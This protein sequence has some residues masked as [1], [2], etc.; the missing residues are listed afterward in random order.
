MS[1]P[2]TNDT[3]AR[4]FLA[5][6][7]DELAAV[8]PSPGPRRGTDR[9]AVLLFYRDGLV[10][11]LE[12]QRSGLVELASFLLEEPQRGETA[13]PVLRGREPPAAVLARLRRRRGLIL[14]F[15]PA[16]ALLVRDLLPAGAEAELREI[17]AH[18]LDVLTPWSADQAVFDVEVSR[19]REDGR[20]EV[21]V[22]VAPRAR[23][24]QLRSR[25]D[26]LGI[27]IERVDVGELDDQP[28]PRFDLLAG[29]RGPRRPTVLLAL[30]GVLA[31]AALA[32]LVVAGSEIH[33]RSV[34]LAERERV[35]NALAER[36]AD[37]PALRTRLEALRTEVGLVA[38]RLRTTPSALAVLEELS[39]ALP[40]EVF[41]SELQLARDRLSVTGYGPS[42]APLVPLLE[43]L[44]S[45]EDVR[46]NAPSTRAAA[47]GFEGARREVERFALVARVT[48]SRGASR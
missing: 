5:W 11:V 44:P 1:T 9:R 10:R 16:H 2:P 26:E 22:A 45:L 36:L 33:A 20:L 31:A 19:V 38:E 28:V 18:R 29:E 43:D 23:V 17:L 4:G 47:P 8:V 32:G 12:R 24:E 21:T 27:A 34:V 25:L 48:G 15:D 46:F 39:R 42:A 14:R 41:L 35:A 3:A 30:I 7:L 37:L 13:L 40:D 6:W